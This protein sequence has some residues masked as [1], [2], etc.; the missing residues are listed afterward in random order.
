[1]VHIVLVMSDVHNF[2]PPCG[3]RNSNSHN[4][5]SSAA[6]LHVMFKGVPAFSAA[7]P[8]AAKQKTWQLFSPFSAN[9][10]PRLQLKLRTLRA[11]V[12]AS[13]TFQASLGRRAKIP[14][15]I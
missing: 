11:L 9:T 7:T 10:L 1:M 13:V 4:P 12:V 14:S 15:S 2:Q 6:L 5:L 8:F 3:T